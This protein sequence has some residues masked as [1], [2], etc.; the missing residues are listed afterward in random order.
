MRASRLYLYS[1]LARLLPS[2]RC[3]ALKRS[4][5]R[6]CGAALGENVR[7]CS[8]ARFAM[9]GPLKIGT[10]TWVGHE[11]LIVGGDAPVVIGSQCDIAPRVLVAS[12]SHVIDSLGTRVAGT[13]Y[14]A[15]ITIGDGTWLCAGSIIL[16]G[17]TIGAR[18][19]VAA[20]AVV[21]G[22]FPEGTIISG[23]PARVTGKIDDKSKAG[24]LRTVQV[25]GV[26]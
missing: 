2:T 24:Q 20:G 15:P 17:T 13:G 19:I 21:K 12:G 7:L 11:V 14:S 23:I 22:N 1:G 9:S 6:L 16:G 5:L 18:C 3:F 25:D 4:L 10:D 26:E 8:S